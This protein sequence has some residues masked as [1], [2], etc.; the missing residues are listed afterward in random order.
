MS[1]KNEFKL[2]NAERRKRR[3]SDSFK[4]K[5]VREIQRGKTR[6]IEVCKQ[7]D[8]S[9]TNVYRWIDKFGAMKTKTERLVVETASDTQELL[10]LKK[11]VAELERLIGQK[12]VEL[13]FKDKMIGLAEATYGVDIKKKF[14]TSR[15]TGFGNSEHTTHGA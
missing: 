8:V 10:R 2:S 13:E 5:K 14:S 6:V 12:Q 7:Y 3:F 1:T 11:Q 9:S 15:S 4:Q